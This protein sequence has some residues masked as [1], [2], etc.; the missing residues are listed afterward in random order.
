[1]RSVLDVP[2]AAF[3]LTIMAY[4]KSILAGVAAFIV[5]VMISSAIALA[6]IVR[7]PQF[8]MRIFPAQQ[9]DLQWGSHYYINFPLWQIIVAGV[10]A[11]VI[12]F[13]WMFRT[14]TRR[15]GV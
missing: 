2:Q 14:A 8:S 1:M 7:F 13:A 5:T 9:F 15:A 11:F 6:L 10:L 3:A 12:G 4:V